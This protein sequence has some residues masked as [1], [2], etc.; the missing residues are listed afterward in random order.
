[1]NKEELQ[2]LLE[3]IEEAESFVDRHSESWYRSGQELLARIR[4]DK[5]LL[6]R[7]ASEVTG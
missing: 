2:R 5:E 7:A 4:A 6:Q 3:T 1:M